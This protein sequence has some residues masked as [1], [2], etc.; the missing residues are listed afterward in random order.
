MSEPIEFTPIDREIA[1]RAIEFLKELGDDLGLRGKVRMGA[2][3][4]TIKNLLEVVDQQSS[5]AEARET[6]CPNCKGAPSFNIGIAKII[7]DRCKGTGMEPGPEAMAAELEELRL[8]VRALKSELAEGEWTPY[9]ENKPTPGQY[10]VMASFEHW[11][12]QEDCGEEMRL[13]TWTGEMWR[14]DCDP[15]E[16]AELTGYTVAVFSFCK[17]TPYTAPGPEEGK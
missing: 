5:A 4:S 2:A 3:I 11:R 13:A 7:C 14:E 1:G 9:P 12:H 15:L 8:L 17:P 10:L 16:K 6:A